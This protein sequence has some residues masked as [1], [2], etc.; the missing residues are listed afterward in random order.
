MPEKFPSSEEI[1]KAENMMTAEERELSEIRETTL[2][3]KGN[4][5]IVSPQE[6]DSS[7]TDTWKSYLDRK[8][9]LDAWAPPQDSPY[10]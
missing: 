7:G 2:G 4:F 8:K 3:D 1:S 5:S 6:I 9:L 10:S